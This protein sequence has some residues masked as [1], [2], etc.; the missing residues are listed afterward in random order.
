MLLENNKRGHAMWWII[1]AVIGIIGI[2]LLVY[3]YKSA[4]LLYD[5]DDIQ[6][7]QDNDDPLK[8]N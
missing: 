1:R 5:P 3:A 4:I 7:L 8:R 2:S 6:A